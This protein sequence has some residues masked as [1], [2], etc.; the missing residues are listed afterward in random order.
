M[1]RAL[2]AIAFL[3]LA[4]GGASAQPAGPGMAMSAHT[5]LLAQLDATQ[6]VGESASHATGTGAFLLDPLGHTLSYALTYQGLEAGGPRS[7]TLHNFGAGKNGRAIAV[8]C[9]SDAAPRCP[10]G[11]S[12]TIDETVPRPALAL[13]NALISEFDS[14]RVYVEIVGG[15]GKPEIRGQLGFNG[16]MVRVSNFVARLAPLPGT[17]ANGRGTAVVSETY[18]PGGTIAVF[19]ALT[20]AGTSGV[21]TNATFAS[22]APSPARPVT[23]K[24]LLPK[25]RVRTSRDPA[26]GTLT[27]SYN[28]NVA[29]RDALY[30]SRFVAAANGHAGL[31]VTTARF[32]GGELFG[33]LVP[34]R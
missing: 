23:S 19:Y 4:G 9:S 5:L 17:N 22:S 20:T 13:D 28:V 8:L 10:P 27:G 16:A 6:V 12:G 25:P 3:A 34:V 31:V 29:A 18:L 32:P 15:G 26:G 2:L 21:P 11:A 14:G 24:L 1:N 7:I 30:A 33:E